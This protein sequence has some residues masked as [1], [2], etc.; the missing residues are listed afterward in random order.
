[1][2]IHH[3]DD[4]RHDHVFHDA[5][6]LQRGERRTWWVIGLTFVTMV[7]EIGAGLAFNSMALLADG[8]HMASHAAALGITVFAY[9]FARRHAQDRRFTFGAGKVGVLGGFTSAVVLAMVAL[10][11]AAESI[12][13]LVN[14]LPIA[15]DQAMMV[16]V[17]GLVV[18]LASAKLLHGGGGHAHHEDHH[19]DHHHHH[20]EH[21]HGR[22]HG[23]HH[24]HGG[25]HDHNLRAAYLHV[26]ADALTSVLAIVALLAGRTWGWVWMDAAMGI[27]GALVVGKWA[28]GLLGDTGSVLLDA[29]VSGEREDRL[30]EAIEADADNRVSDIHLWHVGPN[31][32]GAIVSVVTHQPR[33]V[34]HYR[35]L[36]A[37]QKDL[38]HLTV[39]VHACPG[40]TCIHPETG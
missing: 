1:M 8:W 30:R 20:K 21:H 17:V 25:H 35:A 13:R 19:D 10:L 37:H 23:H 2:H 4:W 39:E 22:H 34:D 27:V 5:D 40:E 7:V 6:A 12:N 33:P 29:S 11:M 38:A 36:L 26:L 28:V 18:N 16:A 14:P 15:F 31:R 9:W 3:M 32:L 24:G